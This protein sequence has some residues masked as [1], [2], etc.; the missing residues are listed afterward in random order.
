MCIVPACTCPIPATETFLPSRTRSPVLAKL[1]AFSSGI[2]RR[3]ACTRQAQS[4]ATWSLKQHEHCYYRFKTLLKYKL[5][6]AGGR[7]VECEEEY[8]SKICSGCGAI[9]TTS[10]AARSCL[11]VFDRDVNTV[12]NIFHKNM[13]LLL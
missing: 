10:A 9:K 13:G 5:E 3:Q 2:R 4:V 11:A 6:R 1:P 8:T 12:R 7:L